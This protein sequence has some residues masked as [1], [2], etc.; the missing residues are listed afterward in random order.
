MRTVP[1]KVFLVIGLL[2]FLFIVQAGVARAQNKP[3][4]TDQDDVIRINTTLVQLHAVITDRKGQVI[5]NIKQE[6]FEVFENGIPQEIKSFSLEQIQSRPTASPASSPEVSTPA[7]PPEAARQSKPHTPTRVVVLFV[8]TL[9]LSSASLLRSKQQLRKFID[10][11]LTDEDLVAVVEPT[12]ALGV[13]QQFMQNRPRLRYAVDKLSPFQ[14]KTSLFTPYLAALVLSEDGKALNVALQ[15]LSAEESYQSVSAEATRSYLQMRAQQILGEEANYR[16]ATLQTLKAISDRLASM[17]GQRMIAYVSDGFT[18]RDSGGG[19]EKQDL[20]AATSSAVR[21]GVLI[22]T[23]NAK[24]LSAPIESQASLAIPGGAGAIDFIDYVNR[25]EQEQKDV[26]RIIADETGARAFLN[27]NDLHNLLNSMLEENRSYYSLAYYPQ[28]DKDK[29]KFR[30]IR[31]QVKN[32]PEYTVRVQN[33]YQPII[34]VKSETAS[35]PHQLL[36]QAMVAPLPAIAIGVTATTNFLARADDDAQAT[37]Q[38]HLDGNALEYPAQGQDHVLKLQL[39]GLVLDRQGKIAETFSEDIKTVLTSAQLSEARSNG[40]RFDR[41]LSM[42]P[43]LYQIRVGVRDM[44]GGGIGTATSWLDVPDL[45]NKKLA[46]SG[47]FLGQG[48]QAETRAATSTAPKKQGP[49]PKLMAG[50]LAFTNN[51]LIYY[52][53]VVYN[54]PAAGVLKN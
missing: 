35:S 16:R 22:Y 36:L 40:F 38:V 24:G 27:R 5:E 42:K 34:E 13:L 10:E 2:G 12:G 45:G 52:R 39:A 4:P 28:D 33:G 20:H 47:V 49:P 1:P 46:I 8:D 23:F 44:A 29:K 53:F 3:A 50:R 54:A 11:Q 7:G 15:I 25:S 32:H 41:R 9:H 43:G 14:P 51:A 17:K 6:D 31:L 21:A 26:L 18:L 48:R 37:L 30:K 19:E